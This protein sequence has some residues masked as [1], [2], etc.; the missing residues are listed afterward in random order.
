MIVAAVLMRGESF[1]F[2]YK[3]EHVYRLFDHVLDHTTVAHSTLLLTDTAGPWPGIDT[4]IR[5]ETPWPGW[6]GK[7]HLFEQDLGSDVVFL[8]LDTAIRGDIGWLLGHNPGPHLDMLLD[9]GNRTR[10]MSSVFCWDGKPRPHLTE[11]FRAAG[12]RVRSDQEWIAHHAKVGEIRFLQDRYPCKFGSL[13][14]WT[15]PAKDDPVNCTDA[16]ILLWHGGG[17]AEFF[18][19]WP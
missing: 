9:V 11:G 1:G 6:W 10:P 19:A 5:P 18:H 17:K 7:L 4:V 16:P 2:R 15:R 12:A 8:D 3:S 14:E 13:K